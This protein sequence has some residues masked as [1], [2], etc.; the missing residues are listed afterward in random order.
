MSFSYSKG[1]LHPRRH[2]V[3]TR[4]LINGPQKLNR[5]KE[6]RIT[7]NSE[8]LHVCAG[9]CVLAFILR[10]TQRLA[11]VPHAGYKM[12]IQHILQCFAILVFAFI[13]NASCICKAAFIC[14]ALWICVRVAS[15]HKYSLRRHGL[16]LIKGSCTHCC[17]SNDNA[18]HN[19]NNIP[20]VVF[21]R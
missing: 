14:K 9:V 20:C 13:C 8:L 5:P 3:Q 12:D 4:A 6:Q 11:S 7:G 10:A 19:A 21:T 1:S 16:V 17:Y 2:F 18:R 15:L